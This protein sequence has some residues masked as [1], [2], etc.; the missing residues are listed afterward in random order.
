[1]RI[2][3]WATM[4]FLVTMIAL[5]VMVAAPTAATAG[6]PTELVVADSMSG[7]NFQTYWQKNVIPAIKQS[8]GVTIKYLSL[9]HI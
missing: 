1:M 8:L 4:A 6:A 3:S 5:G 2:R 7:A 9:I